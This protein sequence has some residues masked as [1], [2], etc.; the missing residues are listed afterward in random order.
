MR[1]SEL[2]RRSGVPVATIKF[3]LR[4]GLI[5]KG[6]ATSATQARYSEDHL[7]RLRL[8]R[9]LTEVAGVPLARV[10]RLLD[11]VDDTG[12]GLHELLGTVQYTLSAGEAGEADGEAP[13]AERVEG[14]LA[15][16]DWRVSPFSPDRRA[17]GR[18][19]EAMDQLGFSPDPG[20]LARY[21]EV[22]HGAAELDVAGIDPDAPRERIVEY[23]A[24]CCTL[25]DRA[26]AS[27]RRMAQ[28]DASARKLHGRAYEA[29]ERRGDAG[30]A[31]AAG[32]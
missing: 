10:R 13:Q 21:A 20:L 11:A 12:L 1:I 27:L 4:E 15:E 24:V 30:A 26:F 31:D 23:M 9:A 16:L 19:L 28:E 2:S 7:R 18:T 6:E 5:P 32:A 29:E 25:M 17:L 3:Y 14:L 8:V 22:A